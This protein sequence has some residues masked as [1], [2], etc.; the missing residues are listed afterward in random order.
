LDAG[1]H[2][3]GKPPEAWVGSAWYQVV[4][5][6]RMAREGPWPE[7]FLYESGDAATFADRGVATLLSALRDGEGRARRGAVELLGRL[8]P[9]APDAEPAPVALADGGDDRLRRAAKR[10]LQSIRAG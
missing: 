8:G 9:L 1:A 7:E 3:L 6:M 10:A 5:R 2:P 4:W